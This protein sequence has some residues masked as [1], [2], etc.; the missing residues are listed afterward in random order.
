MGRG[1]DTKEVRESVGNIKGQKSWRAE[2]FGADMEKGRRIK[3]VVADFSSD[4]FP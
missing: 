4:T 3:K 1:E 2:N